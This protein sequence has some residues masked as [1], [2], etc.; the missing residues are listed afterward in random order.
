MN[1]H[2]K[3]TLTL[4]S[5]LLLVSCSGGGSNNEQQPTITVQPNVQPVLN[6]E[7]TYGE[8]PV[9]PSL[10]VENANNDEMVFNRLTKRGGHFDA[11]K[12]IKITLSGKSLVLAPID[13]SLNNGQLHTLRDTDGNLVGYYGYA[14]LTK[15]VPSF[16]NPDEKLALAKYMALQEG[17]T[18]AKVRPTVDLT[19]QGTMYY[20]LNEAPEQALT[21]DVTAIYHN[22][23]KSITINIFGKEHLGWDLTS[24]ES[25]VTDNG[26]IF[27]R[28]YTMDKKTV[29]GQFDGGLYGKHGEILLG[30]AKNEDANQKENNWKGVIGANANK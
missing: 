20:A 9:P 29:A 17:D 16:Y 18:E 26:S 25:H 14:A 8:K 19:Y 6:P 1:K 24:M 23:K 2:Q 30:E 22:A 28:L 11:D 5:S 4:L 7:N 27:T 3:F 15:T 10:V 12:W 21:A 13:S